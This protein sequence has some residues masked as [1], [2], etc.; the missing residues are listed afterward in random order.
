MVKSKA[1]VLKTS[2]VENR[3]K[4]I[5]IGLANL[6]LAGISVY[7]FDYWITSVAELSWGVMLLNFLVVIG[8]IFTL[9]V[10]KTFYGKGTINNG[11]KIVYTFGLGAGTIALMLFTSQFTGI[12]YPLSG[13]IL[14]MIA[15]YMLSVSA[16]TLN[17]IGMVSMSM[18]LFGFVAWMNMQGYIGWAWTG[19]LS[20]ASV[21]TI[22]FWG[23]VWPHFRRAMHGVH[24]VNKDGGGF[25]SDD[26]GDEDDSEG[27]D[28]G[29]GDGDTGDE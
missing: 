26:S 15:F 21:F 20:E 25:G 23:G 13:L 5:G 10:G 28:G 24:G 8:A 12:G 6:T 14:V 9:F 22:L 4:E 2:I 29:D 3:K 16:N 17:I 27:G 18:V 7:V 19:Y 1:K 11:K